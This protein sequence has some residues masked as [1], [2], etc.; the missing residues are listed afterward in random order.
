MLTFIYSLLISGNLMSRKRLI[1]GSGV[2]SVLGTSVGP[3]TVSTT[4]NASKTLLWGATGE[5]KWTP[6][7]T[8]GT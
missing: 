6:A 1:S 2:L 4:N 5:Q 3:T 8:T 7:L